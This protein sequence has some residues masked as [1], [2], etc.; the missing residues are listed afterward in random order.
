[1]ARYQYSKLKMPVVIVA[2]DHDRVVETQSQSE[3]LH[4]EIRQSS[5]HS[6]RGHG[7]MIHQTATDEVMG[8]V[9]EAANGLTV[10]TAE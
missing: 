8:A 1:M 3:L 2:G 6:L 10:I 7:H 5:F 9:R 4:S